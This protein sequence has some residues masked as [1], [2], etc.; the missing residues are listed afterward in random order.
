MGKDVLE[1][2]PASLFVSDRIKGLG[3]PKG[4]DNKRVLWFTEIVRAGVAEYK[5]VF[6]Q[7]LLAAKNRRDP[8]RVLTL[9]KAVAVHQ[10]KAGIE[11]GGLIGL[12][13]GLFLR[14]PTLSL[15]ILSDRIGNRLPP[16]YRVILSDMARCLDSP[17][18]GHPRK[19]L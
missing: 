14:I 11:I 2:I 9:D 3:K 5:S 6:H 1:K 12:S 7:C 19:N 17:V 4:G 13:V 8:A 18:Q 10:E 15:N 16:V